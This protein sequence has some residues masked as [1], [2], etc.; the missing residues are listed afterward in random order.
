[1]TQEEK[2]AKIFEC[3]IS[4]AN[5]IIA[6]LKMNLPIQGATPKQM[7]EGYSEIYCLDKVDRLYEFLYNDMT[8]ESS[9]A[10]MSIHHTR[11][12]A[13]KAMMEHKENERLKYEKQMERNMKLWQDNGFDEKAISEF[14]SIQ[15]F[16][17]FQG[18]MVKE[19]EVLQ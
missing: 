5:K 6:S 19:V 17:R 12:G 4:Y 8:E 16:G 1:M 3:D 11:E 14:K 13:E 9:Y 2:I 7:F 10:T 18:W 15:K